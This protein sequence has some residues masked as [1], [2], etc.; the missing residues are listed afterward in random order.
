MIP[1]PTMSIDTSRESGENREP[2]SAEQITA[3]IASVQHWYHR[4]EVRPGVRTPGT[5]DSQ[6]ALE[7]LGLPQDCSGLTALDIGTRD[8]FFAFELER[9]GAA[10][11]AVD[12]APA[13]TTGFAVAAEL[14]G[15]RVPYV[16]ADL[17]DLSAERLGTFDLVLFLGVLYHLPDPIHA[18]TIVRSLCRNRMILETHVL[19]ETGLMLPDGRFDSLRSLS[20][21]LEEIPLL[22]FYPG[23]S[24]GGDYTNW[25]APNLKCLELMLEECGFRVR[26]GRIYDSRAVVDCEAATPSLKSRHNRIVQGL[27]KV[28]EKSSPGG[29]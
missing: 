1:T 10:V 25:W 7:R 5:N 9:R 19:D 6:T 22:Q 12:Y 13:G 4:I 8:G 11:L 18:L 21:V 28:P 3:R 16:Q 14:L 27:A 29:G 20:P 24:L 23:A 26:G 17:Y 15:A 2:L